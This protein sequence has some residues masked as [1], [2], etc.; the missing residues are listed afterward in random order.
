[1]RPRRWP[2][3][4][5][6]STSDRCS[7]PIPPNRPA[8][9]SSISRRGWRKVCWR[10]TRRPSP[11]AA[12]SRDDSRARGRCCGSPREGGAARPPGVGG[13]GAPAEQERGGRRG[14]GEQNGR[15]S[16]DEPLRMKISF[17]RARVD[18][19]PPG[20]GSS[21]EL[22]RD[23]TLVADALKAVGAAHARR[24]LVE[25]LLAQVRSHGF[26]GYRLDVREDAGAHTRALRDLTATIGLGEL[27]GARSEE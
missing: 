7:P 25:P 14:V 1:M 6:R 19:D 21:G 4:C 26:H 17:M 23:L 15:R 22:E 27:D 10:G 24:T 2:A 16:A 13:G 18:A 11:S 3:R 20:Y 8:V 12:R 5:A 9:P